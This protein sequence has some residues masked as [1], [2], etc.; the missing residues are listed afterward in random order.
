M[1]SNTMY[2]KIAKKLLHRQ[3]VQSQINSL[4][5]PVTNLKIGRY[6]LKPDF[7]TQERISQ[8]LQ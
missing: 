6:V 1:K 2:Q 3:N 5:T 7:V 8:K 4:F